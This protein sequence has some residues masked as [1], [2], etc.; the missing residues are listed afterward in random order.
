MIRIVNMIPASLS[1]E[2]SQD[3]EPN[4]AVNPE[5]PTDMVGTAF[6]RAMGGAFA[7]IYVSTD[8]GATWSLRNVVPGNGSVGTSDITVGFATSG[9]ILYAG[10]LNGSTGHLQILR[11]SG[12]TSSTPMTV[13][14]DRASEDQPWVVAGSVMV[15]GLSRDRVFVGN[16]D[17]NQPNGQ[18]ATIDMSADAAAAPAPAGFVARAVERRATAG[19]DGPPIRVAVHASGAVYGALH[20]WQ[21]ANGSNITMDIVVVRD[22]A[23]GTSASPFG[24]LVDSGDGQIGQ[25]VATGRFIRF[26]DT[27]GQ[28]RLGADLT[29]AVDP[30][31]ASTVYLAWCDRVGGSAGTDWTIHVR[32]S[33]DSGQTW[34]KDLRTITNA[35]NPALAVNTA[36]K[37]GFL[38]QQFTGIRWVTQLELTTNAWASA[39]ETVVLHT[40][41]S[42]APARTFFPFVGDYVRL[43][44]VDLDFY[45]VF[46]GNNAPDAANF[47]NG[48][49][50][51]RFANWTTHTLLNTDN[52]TPVAVSIDPF[53][54]LYSDVRQW[55]HALYADLLGRA[56]DAG[57]LAGW[58]GALQSGQSRQSVVNG[59]INSQEYCT[60]IITGLFQQLLGRAPD[61][62]GLAW[63]V[64]TMQGGTALQ[65]IILGFCDS[66]EYQGDNPPPAQFVE[67]LYERLLGRASDPAGKQGWIDALQAG[68]GTSY[69]IN[70]FLNSQEYCSNRVAGLYQTLL[71]RQPDAAG[72]AFWVTALTE[73]TAFQQIQLGFLTSV[74]YQ[75]RALTRFP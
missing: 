34:S 22:D 17:F 54:F 70:G 52:V 24:A 36:G 25:R 13:L 46:S 27:L 10:T 40:A 45:G 26:N 41:P 43:L 21:T 39:A 15:G 5:S 4:I 51:Q 47:P 69:V 35:K 9:G 20:S 8:G 32:R 67:S 75:A 71:G 57:G 59:F 58:L 60:A 50:Y 66:P 16:N 55:L 29:I 64:N 6:T 65:Q 49:A 37:V 18:T 53:F 38:F 2:S 61:A 23:W 1:G 42:N 11:T 63:W 62:G 7:P 48:I 56:P 19:Q 31:S 3:S 44:A 12:F 68:H 73:G 33:S 30:M 72:L 14:V 74:E 28:E